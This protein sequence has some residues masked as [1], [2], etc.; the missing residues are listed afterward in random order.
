[1]RDNAKKD[2][3]YYEDI[4]CAKATPSGSSAIAVIRVS[5]KDCWKVL[6]NIFR[7]FNNKNLTFKSHRAL[8]GYIVDND[9]IIDNVLIITF[10]NGKSF[11]GEESFEIHCHGS[12]VI[13][14]L[15]IN[16]LLKNGCRLAEPGEFSK[17]AF[18]NGKIDLTEAEAIMDLV[19]ASTKEAA[20]VANRQLN[21]FVRNEINSI[22]ERIANLLATIEV[23]ID[24]PDED[25]SIN[26]KSCL[27]EFS[28]I[29][30]FL[31]NLLK[32]FNRGRFFR[33]GITAV[34]LG[35]TNSG[36]STIFNYLLNEDKAIVSNIHGT[37]RDYLDAV[38]NIQGYGVRLYDTAGLRITDDPI[39]LEGAKRARHIAINS[40]I[41][42]Y[43]VDIEVG[44]SN[45]DK[46]NLYEFPKEKKIML[47]LNKIDKLNIPLDNIINDIRNELKD[48]KNLKI[49]QMSGLN[50]KGIEEFNDLFIE[51][52]IQNK[53][54]N[55]I[56]LIT[57]LRHANLIESAL[58]NIAKSF[59]NISYGILDI[60][61]FEI[62][63]ALN[64]LGEITGEVT[65]EDIINRIFS[66]FCVGK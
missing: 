13:A 62:R 33:E 56:S 60:A 27:E 8:Y 44:F 39:E 38:I 46:I 12:E 61:A 20:R 50:K 41:I 65:K 47:I 59:E 57:N 9:N 42:L 64:R 31:S 1:M 52:L 3:L 43:V 2:N 29:S 5:G 35:K 26:I 37:T 45:E 19:N 34:L 7:S 18:L 16:L 22:K 51:L 63:E 15:I 66:K 24:Y 21:G 36:K 53:K 30:D 10:G 49:C 11:T 25:L 4:I 54:E 48:F 6:S 40:D 14:T 55:D 32:S 58:K 23:F 17:R 28:E